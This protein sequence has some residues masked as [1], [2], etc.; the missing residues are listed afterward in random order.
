MDTE[1][2]PFELLQTEEQFLKDFTLGRNMVYK[3]QKRFEF[4]KLQKD[5]YDRGLY[6]CLAN[7][8]RVGNVSKEEFEKRFDRLDP[9]HSDTYKIVVG[10]DKALDRVV[11]YGTIFFELK[12]VEELGICGHIEDI[13]VHK[14]YNGLHL[15]RHVIFMLKEISKINL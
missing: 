3:T 11:C 12:F 13:V 10:I 4:R 14:E 5:D 6:E 1:M 8:T 7:L 15:G 2:T 9:Q